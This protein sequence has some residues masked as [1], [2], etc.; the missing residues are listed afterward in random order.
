MHHSP[1]WGRSPRLHRHTAQLQLHWLSRGEHVTLSGDFG[2]PH[3]TPFDI[4][5]IDSSRPDLRDRKRS[6][7]RVSF[8][9][10]C[11]RHDAVLQMR[12]MPDR[13][14]MPDQ[15]PRITI[16]EGL[17]PLRANHSVAIRGTQLKR[18]F[19]V[20]QNKIRRLVVETVVT[21]CWPKRRH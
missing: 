1:W 19:Y 8:P 12:A 6:L 2:L 15:E 16:S 4:V 17:V 9:H 10:T 5:S 18:T 21:V 3:Q 11:L 7:E 20:A 13:N 14:H